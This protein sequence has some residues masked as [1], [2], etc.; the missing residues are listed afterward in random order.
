MAEDPLLV[1][2]LENFPLE[3]QNK[4]KDGGGLESFLLDSPCFT[5]MGRFISL[6]KHAVSMQQTECRASLDDLDVVE[7]S[8]TNIPPP[9]VHAYDFNDTLYSYSSKPIAV[10]PILP[11]P[12]IL[13]A[14]PVLTYNGDSSLCAPVDYYP[15]TQWAI[16]DDQQEA[17]CFSHNDLEEPDLYS[18][19]VDSELGN[20]QTSVTTEEI[21]FW[22]HSAVQVNAEFPPDE[23]SRRYMNT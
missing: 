18:A 20:G 14:Q 6:A 1:G 15:L 10:H 5:K 7:D 16:G 19:E 21:C 11:N 8:V 3:A 2:E 12:Y 9:Y 13:G 22:K 23:S 4:I 17:P